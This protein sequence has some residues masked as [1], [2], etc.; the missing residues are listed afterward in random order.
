MPHALKLATPEEARV[1]EMHYF[2]KRPRGKKQ[3]ETRV[4]RCAQIAHR[5][6]RA[7]ANQSHIARERLFGTGSLYEEIRMGG[8][9]RRLTVTLR[10]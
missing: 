7:D 2:A 9:W 10:G 1:S 8:M 4:F 5:V 3:G 6:A